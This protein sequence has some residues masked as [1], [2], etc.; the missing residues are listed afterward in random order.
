MIDTHTNNAQAL[1][2][3][4]QSSNIGNFLMVLELT[5]EVRFEHSRKGV[6]PHPHQLSQ[7]GA[8]IPLV[9]LG[10]GQ[11]TV[12]AVDTFVV[13]PGRLLEK[14]GSSVEDST[15]VPHF[16]LTHGESGWQLQ[17]QCKFIACVIE[18]GRARQPV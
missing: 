9:G 10:T 1:E 15:V 2:L 4:R 3:M 18:Q 12:L 8:V 6:V 11:E 16:Q 7:E 13:V 17:V 5:L 14:D